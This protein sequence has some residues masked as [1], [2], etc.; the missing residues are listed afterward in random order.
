MDFYI[1][2]GYEIYRTDAKEPTNIK[3]SRKIGQ[4]SVT[5]RLIFCFISTSVHETVTRV[6]PL[7]TLQLPYITV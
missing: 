5:Q 3:N 7:F 6:N 4:L 1:I 2:R